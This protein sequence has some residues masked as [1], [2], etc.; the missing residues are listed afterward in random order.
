MIAVASGRRVSAVR[1]QGLYPALGVPVFRLLWGGLLPAQG[2]QATRVNTTMMFLGP[3][4][5][6]PLAW[7]ADHLG[8]R[9][10]IGGCGLCIVLAVLGVLAAKRSVRA[11]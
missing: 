3:I 1:L 10:M 8:D 9:L 11:S 5:T 2:A 7:L 4:V 6:P